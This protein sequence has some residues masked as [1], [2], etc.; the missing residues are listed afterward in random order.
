[1]CHSDTHSSAESNLACKIGVFWLC[2]FWL[3]WNCPCVRTL[4]QHVVPRHCCIKKSLQI[5]R[6]CDNTK[7]L[8]IWTTHN[9]WQFSET[10]AHGQHD[11]IK[12]QLHFT[13]RDEAVSALMAEATTQSLEGSGSFKMGTTQAIFF[14]AHWLFSCY[15]H[16]FLVSSWE[17]AQASAFS[18]ASSSSSSSSELHSESS[19]VRVVLAR[20]TSPTNAHAWM[21]TSSHANAFTD[22]TMLGTAQWWHDARIVVGQCTDVTMLGTPQW[23]HDARIV[24]GWCVTRSI[25][26]ILMHHAHSVCFLHFATIACHCSSIRPALPMAQKHCKLI[27]QGGASWHFQHVVKT[28]PIEPWLTSA[29]FSRNSCFLTCAAPWRFWQKFKISAL[30]QLFVLRVAMHSFGVTCLTSCILGS[31]FAFWGL[32]FAMWGLVLNPQ[33]R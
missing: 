3:G 1:M 27:H 11:R 4:W 8:D 15:A 24:V 12:E 19:T 33:C 9:A 31:N 2:T 26:R 7:S 29:I 16:A 32:C 25:M 6:H 20:V 28:R 22:V 21:H 13:L 18:N 14:L 30:L 17:M 23:W 10:A 5:P